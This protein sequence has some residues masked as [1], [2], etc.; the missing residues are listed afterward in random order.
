MAE[1]LR[2]PPE[3]VRKKV[4]SGEALFVCAYEDEEKFRR[5]HLEGAV[6]FNEFKIKAESLTKEQEL[7]F[8]CA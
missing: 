3:E 8:Y 1:P 5:M 4:L 6:S 7:I 2:I